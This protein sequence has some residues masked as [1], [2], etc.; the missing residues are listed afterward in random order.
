MEILLD[1]IMYNRNLSVRQ[2]SYMTGIPRSTISDIICGRTS[3][4]LDTLEAIA[5]GLNI[6][7]IELFDSPYK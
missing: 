3:P 7:I 1:K 5:K 6:S 2:V 4:R